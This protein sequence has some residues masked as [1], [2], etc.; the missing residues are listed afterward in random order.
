MTRPNTNVTFRNKGFC[1]LRV[2]E[3]NQFYILVQER[4]LFYLLLNW[5]RC[6]VTWQAE[7]TVREM[8]RMLSLLSA[9]LPSVAAPTPVFCPNYSLLFLSLSVHVLSPSPSF[10]EY[11]KEKKAFILHAVRTIIRTSVMTVLH[12]R[13][14][15][16]A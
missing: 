15:D 10:Y 3:S 6:L 14:D 5:S 8:I 16:S 1:V 7:V 9:H 4:F 12:H 13:A 2:T 11:T